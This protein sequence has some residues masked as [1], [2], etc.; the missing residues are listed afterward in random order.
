[1]FV[2]KLLKVEMHSRNMCEGVTFYGKCNALNKLNCEQTKRHF[3]TKENLDSQ[4]A[5][6]KFKHGRVRMLRKYFLKYM[7]RIALG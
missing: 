4:S 1:M 7:S 6:P 3:F 5:I 2:V